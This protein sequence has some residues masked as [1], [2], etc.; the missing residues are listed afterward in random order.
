MWRL[1]HSGACGS[2]TL[3][4]PPGAS[5]TC[6]LGPSCDVDTMVMPRGTAEQPECSEALAREKMQSTVDPAS[7]MHTAPDPNLHREQT[8]PSRAA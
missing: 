7:W 1:L 8:S 6:Y 3:T 5:G 4:S 2:P